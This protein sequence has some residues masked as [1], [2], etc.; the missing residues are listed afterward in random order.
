MARPAVSSAPWR[1]T[2]APRCSRLNQDTLCPASTQACPRASRKWVLPVPEG[3]QTTRFSCRSTHSRVRRAR[4]VGAGIDDSVSVEACE[5]AGGREGVPDVE[6]LAG[7][8][9]RSLAPRSDAGG[10]ASGE[11]LGEQGA[12]GFRGFPTLR[13]RCREQL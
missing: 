5:A 8:E 9:P 11:L 6:G 3:P 4:W 12:D 7:R 13:L 1:R 2:R 10:L